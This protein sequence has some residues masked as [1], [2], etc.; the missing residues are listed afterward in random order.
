ML[1]RELIEHCR[2][3][4]ATYEL[5]RTID[6]MREMPRERTGKLRTGLLRQSYL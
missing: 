1:E 5:P 6:F 2:A 4:L 3:H